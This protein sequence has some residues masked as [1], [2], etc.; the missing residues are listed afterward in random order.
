MKIV[1]RFAPSP[2]GNLHIGSARTAL[3]NWLF[4]KNKK[5]K[6]SI[7]RYMSAHAI[8]IAFDGIPAIYFNSIFGTSND[9]YKY[10][11]SGNNEDIILYELSVDPLSTTIISLTLIVWVIQAVNYLDFV[12]ED[13]HS[14]KV[15]FMYSLLSLPKIFNKEN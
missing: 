12:S 2:T 9:E 4:A 6:F 14:F 13:G 15:Y 10:I 5:G 8:M 11:I 3:F 1:T 7:E